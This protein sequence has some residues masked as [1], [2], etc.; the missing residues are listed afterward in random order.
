MTIKAVTRKGLALKKVWRLITMLL[1]ITAKN[2][3]YDETKR[4]P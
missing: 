3:R 2:A 1:P 4:G